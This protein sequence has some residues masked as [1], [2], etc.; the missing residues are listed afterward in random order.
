[1][2][3]RHAPTQHG[4]NDI[5]APPQH[6]YDDIH[7]PQAPKILT[8]LMVCCCSVCHLDCLGDEKTQK[9]VE[10][11]QQRE[12]HKRNPS[13]STH[14]RQASSPSLYDT[15]SLTVLVSSEQAKPQIPSTAFSSNRIIA[16]EGARPS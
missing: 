13:F 12:N 1:M 3:L 7:A 4:Y 5:H 11:S 16:R 9:T 8:L 14:Q 2:Y 6:G 10:F 15:S